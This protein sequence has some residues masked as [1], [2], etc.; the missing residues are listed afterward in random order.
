MADHEIAI[1]CALAYFWWLFLYSFIHYLFYIAILLHFSNVVLF[2]VL[3]VPVLLI[4]LQ[5]AYVLV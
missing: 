2:A 5:C 3:F 4:L 1:V